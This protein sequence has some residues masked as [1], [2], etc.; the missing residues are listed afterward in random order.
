MML[1]EDEYSRKIEEDVHRLGGNTK[2]R[3]ICR[4]DENTCG[5]GSEFSVN[6]TLELSAAFI[7]KEQKGAILQIQVVDDEA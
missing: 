7:A 6:K 3:V 1:T 4:C 2:F 5:I